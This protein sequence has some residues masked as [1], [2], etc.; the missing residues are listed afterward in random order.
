MWEA[1]RIEVLLGNTGQ[2]AIAQYSTVWK[3]VRGTGKVALFG[4]LLDDSAVVAS[5]VL[6]YFGAKTTASGHPYYNMKVFLCDHIEDMEQKAK[7]CRTV[8]PKRLKE[9]TTAKNLNEFAVGSVV[10]VTN[11]RMRDTQFEGV[12][13]YVDVAVYELL[14]IKAMRCVHS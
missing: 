7:F 9:T 10:L 12:A 11:I 1:L 5:V 6:A 2:Y 13:E 3:N 8:D 4:T 14:M